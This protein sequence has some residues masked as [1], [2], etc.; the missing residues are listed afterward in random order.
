MLGEGTSILAGLTIFGGLGF[1]SKSFDLPIDSVA[2]A[3]MFNF[4]CFDS[5]LWLTYTISNMHKGSLN[6][7]AQDYGYPTS[8]TFTFAMPLVDA[9]TV[10]S[11]GG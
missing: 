4:K 11:H 8:I 2:K 3:G 9:W 6:I 7:Y 1:I 10:I 5:G